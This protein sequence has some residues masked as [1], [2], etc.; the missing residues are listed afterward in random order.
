MRKKICTAN[1]FLMMACLFYESCVIQVRAC[2]F[3]SC[4]P[5]EVVEPLILWLIMNVVLTIAVGVFLVWGLWSLADGIC[6]WL[7]NKIG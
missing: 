7:R 4:F 1:I 3:T 5:P 2:W 6:E